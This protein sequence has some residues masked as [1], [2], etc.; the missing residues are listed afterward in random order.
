MNKKK[1]FPLFFICL[2]V[3]SSSFAIESIHSIE[4][5]TIKQDSEEVITEVIEEPI[6]YSLDLNYYRS[7]Y[8]NS[9]IIGKVIIDNTNIDTL[10]TKTNDNDFYLSHSLDRSYN[11]LGSLFLD[12]RT[13]IT[14]KKIIIY[15]HNSYY[16]DTPFKELEKYLDFNYY[17]KHKYII[18]ITENSYYKYEIFSIYL[19]SE[20]YEYYKVVINDYQ[21]HLQ[22]LKDKSIFNTNTDIKDED[23]IVLQTCSNSY[24][25]TFLIIVGK[26]IEKD[27]I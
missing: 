5:L 23:I 13:N 7:F 3:N 18:V 26:K 8:N 11:Q 9:D 10:F 6:H 16:Y 1:F 20:D 22:Y 24:K 27:G 2:L 15:G 25:D 21:K 19:T 17:N 4:I 12:Y 14:D